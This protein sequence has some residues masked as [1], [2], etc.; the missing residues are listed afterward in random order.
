MIDSA[1]QAVSQ[2]GARRLR[3]G[4]LSLYIVL[5]AGAAVV[6]LPF[7]WMV[8][9]SLMS[10]G[11]TINRQWLPGVPRWQNYQTAWTEARFAVYFLNSVI[12]TFT[13]LAGLLATS[14]LAAY[15]FARLRFA[16]REIIFFGLLSTM[17]IPEAMTLLPSFLVIRGDVIPLPGGSWL[18]TLQGLTVP[19]MASAFSIFLL[20]QFF[21]RLPV[22]LWDAACID[23]CGHLRFLTTVVLPLSK[24]PL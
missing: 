22:E 9:T 8:S 1:A 24:A 14:V 10:L 20:R 21:R 23:G 4:R 17:M 2:S 16:G 13:S 11:E 15:A 18:N 7:C 6:A 12:I 3:P 5:V 19:F